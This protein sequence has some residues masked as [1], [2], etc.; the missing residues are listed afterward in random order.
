LLGFIR[1]AL[2]QFLDTLHRM[3]AANLTIPE[4][5]D[6]ECFGLDRGFEQLLGTRYLAQE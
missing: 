1:R 3:L 6:R 5:L 4:F 2:A